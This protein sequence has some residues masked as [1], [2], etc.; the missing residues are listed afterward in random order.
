[1]TKPWLESIAIQGFRSFGQARQEFNLPPS[2][3]VFW[4]GNSQGKTSFVEALE[5]LLT[6]QIARRELLAS[7]KDEFAE[8]MRNAHLQPLHPVI[9]QATVKCPDGQARTF[10]RTLINDY[11]RGSAAGCVS[12]IEIDGQPCTEAEVE[13]QLGIRLSHP[14]LRAPVLAQHTLGYLFSVS[15][16]DRAAY[17]RAILDTQDLEDFRAAVAALQPLLLAPTLPELDDLTAAEAIPALAGVVS[18]VRR[19]KKASDIEKA[20]ASCTA[21]LLDAAGIKPTDRLIEQAEQIDAELQRRRSR[22]FPVDM[23][24]RA[25]LSTWDGPSATFIAAAKTFLA[26]REKTDAEIRRLVDLFTAALKLHEHPDGLEPIDCPLCGTADALTPERINFIREQVRSAE[27]YTAALAAFRSAL[28]SLDGQLDALGQAAVRAQPRFMREAAASRRA[29]G[30]TVARAA[31]LVTNADAIRA[32]LDVVSPLWRAMR[33]LSREIG[34]ARAAITAA[35][36]GAEQWREQQSLMGILAAVGEAHGHAS[37]AIAAYESPAKALGEAVKT[38]VDQSADT[39]GWEAL[40]RLSRNPHDLWTAL[41]IAASHVAKLKG[42]EKALADIDTANGKVLD[43]KF[44]DLSHGVKFWWDKLR[45]DETAYFESVQ[46]RSE[47]ARRT[48]NI[49]VGLAAKEDRSDAKIR[50]AI[51]VFSQSQ[52]HCLGLSLFLARAVHEGAGFVILDDPV[53]T[54]DDDYR[55]NFASSVLEALLALGMQTIICTQ[56]HRT[57]RDIGNRWNYKGVEQFQLIRHD[58]TLGTEVRGQ[59]DDLTTMMAKAQR[60]IKSADPIVRKDGAVRLREAIER[61]AKMLI[62]RD[63][64]EKGE[65]LAS[66]TDYDGKD[67]G[68]YSAQAYALLVKDPSHPGK[69]RGHFGMIWQ[70]HWWGLDDRGAV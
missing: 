58:P 54:S 68:S 18:R 26:E 65:A 28:R 3:G 29:A 70:R 31:N 36:N 33:K 9:V 14:P 7:T 46:R 67:F 38:A 51:A 39:K 12:T 40:I 1:M 5:F 43:D 23:F 52:L 49:K 41:G 66:I 19:A 47:R 57:W 21:V 15:P 63:R 42:L 32:W 60:L 6:G 62:V 34:A 11:R 55:P 44:N 8:A 2:A 45:P 27:A 69:L 16:T 13:S 48:I 17:F 10:R 4:G 25:S 59:N 64:R 56:D 24:S 20:L 30:F 61:F 37:E 22:T 53:L 50:D 35:L